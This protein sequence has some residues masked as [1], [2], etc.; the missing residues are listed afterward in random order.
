MKKWIFIGGLLIVALIFGYRWYNDQPEQKINRAVDQLIE[1]IEYSKLNFRERSD[2]HDAI[3]EVTTETV[4]FKGESP[5]PEGE[6]SV[7]RLFNKL[8]LLHTMTTLRQFTELERTLLISG[9]EAQVTR[10]NEIKFAAGSSYQDTQT[11]KLIFDLELHG[12]WRI[13]RIRGEQ[14]Q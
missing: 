13:I 6:I 9:S 14:I 12:Q 8:D 7:D 5:L 10:T 1:A 11:W 4:D 2:V 3:R